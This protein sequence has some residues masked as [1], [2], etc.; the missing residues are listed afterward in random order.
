MTKSWQGNPW[1]YELTTSTGDLKAAE[2]FYGKV[3][4]WTFEDSGMDGF[5]YHL[6]N[7]DGQAV[8]GLS[9]VA[10]DA[11]S[12]LPFWL[13]YFAVESADES[14]ANAEAAGAVVHSVPSDVPGT[15]RFAILTDPQG[16]EFGLLQPDMSSMSGSDVTKAE[17]GGGAFNQ[18]KPGHGNWHE[19]MSTDPAAAFEFYAQLLGWSKGEPVEMGDLGTYQL[20]SLAG[21]DIGGMM[22]LGDAPAPT[23]LP[24]F[25]VDGS[26]ADKIEAIKTAG[27]TVHEGPMEVPGGAYT[28][29]AQDPQGA[30]FAVVGTKK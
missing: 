28:A 2:E 30:W 14:A 10:N 23:W 24:Y 16:A 5:D 18:D 9:V 17:A 11:A 15:G 6:A 22:G 19:L 29:V 4:G 12:T 13:I 21:A 26:V 3:L 20:F 25:G 1:W 7:C 8:A 27:G